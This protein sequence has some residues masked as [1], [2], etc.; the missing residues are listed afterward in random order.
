MTWIDDTILIRGEEVDV[1]RGKIDHKK[2]KFYPENPRLYSLVKPDEGEPD[3]EAIQTRLIKMDH[4]KELVQSIKE[5]GGLMEPIFVHG[6]TFE[7]LEG[8]S[9]LAAYRRLSESDPFTWAEMKCVLLPPSFEKERIF[10]FLG[11]LHIVGKKDWA[12]F[13]QAGFLYRRHK[14]EGIPVDDIAAQMNLPKSET[15]NLI[16]TYEYML[17]VGDTDINKWS[18][19][20][21]FIK[22]RKISTIIKKTPEFEKFL[23]EKIKTGQ[24][25]KAADVRDAVP[26]L[27]LARKNL[28]DK[29]VTGKVD[30]YDAIERVEESGNADATYLRLKRFRDWLLTSETKTAI[31]G[32]S[33]EARQKVEF[34]LKQ[35]AKR[36]QQQ[37]KRLE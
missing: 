14:R 24:F 37:L 2:L 7:V 33:N 19:Y 22:S 20:F 11:Q 13:E 36:V 6:A 21:E 4:V 18:Y 17:S 1:K 8:N 23:V 35:I 27:S 10:A 25:K 15:R 3:Q 31:E 28:I 16:K 32:T 26:K 30:I 12:P 5:N 29:V 9:R 34:E